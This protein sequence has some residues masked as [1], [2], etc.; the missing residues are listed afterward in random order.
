VKVL[1]LVHVE[2]AFRSYFPPDYLETL[3]A[4]LGDYDRI[5]HFT[6]YI[7]NDAPVWEIAEMVGSQVEWGWGYNPDVFWYEPDELTWI[8]PAMGHEYTWVPPQLRNP[9][10]WRYHE[11]WVGG[12][13]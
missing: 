4:N 8:I 10:T 12:G 11:I 6:S 2:D 3:V 7:E 5:M 13:Y 9:A 1:F